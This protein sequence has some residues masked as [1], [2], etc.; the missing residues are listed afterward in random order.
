MNYG[1]LGKVKIAIERLTIVN[2][3]GN[4]IFTIFNIIFMLPQAN[5]KMSLR[6]TNINFIAFVRYLAHPQYENMS[7]GFE[8]FFLYKY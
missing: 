3:S 1:N 6:L 7:V 5:L 4:F 2:N 8:R